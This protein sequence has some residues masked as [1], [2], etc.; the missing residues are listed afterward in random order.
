MH[1]EDAG[2]WEGTQTLTA[3]FILFY[4]SDPTM[5]ATGGYRLGATLLILSL[6]VTYQNTRE[7]RTKLAEKPAEGSVMEEASVSHIALLTF[8]LFALVPA[9]VLC[10]HHIV[11]RPD[12][13]RYPFPE[14]LAGDL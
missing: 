9:R 5:P 4:S 3:S 10:S 8:P 7:V 11:T 13:L 14:G 6:D 12:S 2:P 1:S